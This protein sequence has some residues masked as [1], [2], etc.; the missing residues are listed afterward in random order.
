MRREI[1]ARNLPHLKDILIAPSARIVE[2]Q[3]NHMCGRAKMP[4]TR[5]C[6]KLEPQSA[7]FDLRARP[8]YQT[9]TVFKVCGASGVRLSQR[10]RDENSRAR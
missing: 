2:T 5:L 4:V 3:L 10:S 1:N 9:A 7:L 8:R 6:G